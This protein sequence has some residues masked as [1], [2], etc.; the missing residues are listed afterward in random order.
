MDVKKI[1][2]VGAGAMGSGI[3]Q[4]AACSGFRVSLVD[5]TKEILERG[6]AKIRHGIERGVNSGKVQ[7]KTADEALARLSIGTS[8][9]EACGDAELVIE[10]VSESMDLKKRVFAAL[11]Q[12]APAGAILASNT[13]QLSVTAMAS[14]TGRPDRVIGMHWFN[15]PPLMRLIE[16]ARTTVTSD[17]TLAVVRAVAER[18]GKTVVVCRDTQGFITSRALGAHLVECMRI[19]EEGV[20]TPQEI[21]TA[22]KLGLGYPMGPFELS[23]YVGLDVIYHSAVGLAAAYGDRFRPPQNLV[24][25]VEAG[26]LGAKTGRGFY[27]HGE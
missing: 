19:V 5:L 16:I 25:L 2:V 17:E 11:D 21:D 4:V 12:A 23:D 1:A 7:Q 8:L 10:S 18:M 3:A 26:H 13:S 22:I 15:P 27:P 14:A 20:A 6:L 24:K 9:A